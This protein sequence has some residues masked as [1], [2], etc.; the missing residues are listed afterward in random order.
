M[1]KS[2]YFSDKLQTQIIPCYI[3]SFQS[4]KVKSNYISFIA[5][6]CDYCRKDFLEINPLQ[7]QSYFNYLVLPVKA[8]KKRPAPSTVRLKYA[9]LHAFSNYLIRNASAYDI[10]YFN[11]PFDQVTIQQEDP[12][13]NPLRIPTP[14]QLNNI[15]HK[16]ESEPALYAALSLVIKCGFTVGELTKLRQDFFILDDSDQAAVVFTYRGLQR[17]IKIPDDVLAV[18]DYYW[19]K[20]TRNSAYLFENKSGHPMRVRDIERLYR[21]CMGDDFQFTLADLRNGCIAL[22]LASGAPAKEI[23][24]YVGVRS[25][26]W[27]HRYDKVIPELSL[28]PCDYSNLYIKCPPSDTISSSDP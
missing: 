5:S 12:N 20:Q 27:L 6:I 21:K 28:A 17:C 19:N 1:K 25:C 9:S 2:I 4:E 24:N 8:K 11:N 7:A 22:L 13:L 16:C 23:G 14:V 18:L 26:R 3:T 10:Q 15:L